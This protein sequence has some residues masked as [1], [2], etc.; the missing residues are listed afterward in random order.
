M[1][2]SVSIRSSNVNEVSVTSVT[3]SI[4]SLKRKGWQI[5]TVILQRQRWAWNSVSL[6]LQHWVGLFI[7]LVHKRRTEVSSA[8]FGGSS[9]WQLAITPAYAGMDNARLFWYGFGEKSDL[10][11]KIPGLPSWCSDRLIYRSCTR[12]STGSMMTTTISS[13][14]LL[15][16]ADWSSKK[17]FAQWL[18]DVIIII[19]TSV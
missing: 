19:H 6:K 1:T 2:R 14:I 12:V 4:V 9:R 8:L 11:P 16:S 15:V 10:E 3:I 7:S 5:A 17:L 13:S 18:F